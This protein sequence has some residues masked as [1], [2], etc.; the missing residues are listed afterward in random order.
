MKFTKKD[1]IIIIGAGKVAWSLAPSLLDA[2]YKIKTI[3]SRDKKTAAEL[4]HKFKIREYSDNSRILKIKKG[5]FILAVPDSAIKPVAE[6]LCE[7]EIGFDKS[8]FIHLS[9][10]N[11]ITILSSLKTKKAY[12]AS[13]HILQTFPSRKRR[14]IKNCYSAIET[15]SEEAFAYLLKLSTR[16][17]LNPFRINSVDKIIYHLAGVYASNFINSVLFQSRKLFELLNLREYSFNDLFAPLFISTIK[18]IAESGPAEAL[19]GPVERGDYETVINHIRE[20]RKLSCKNMDIL[21]SYL[22]LSLWLINAAEE[23]SGSLNSGQV[24][25]KKLLTGELNKVDV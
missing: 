16:L 25:I 9:G 10:T 19:S 8:L 7:S 12:T 5:I 20:I 23:K 4:A 2:G 17:Q 15:E 3:I 11:D 24:E 1:P 22:S 6:K 14:R 13:F 18:N 21:Q